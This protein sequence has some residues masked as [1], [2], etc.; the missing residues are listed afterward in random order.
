MTQV[1]NGQNSTE[2][3]LDYLEA[4]LS[5]IENG[6]L[7]ANGSLPYGADYF[8][9]SNADA[10]GNY[11][12]ITYKTGGAAGTTIRI[13]T[14]TFDASGNVLTWLDDAGNYFIQSN[15]DA[16]GNYQTITYKTGGAAGTVTAVNTLTFDAEGNVLTS[17]IV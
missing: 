12:T 15:A 3:Q 4:I 10:N 6:G 7:P 11:Q 17:T 9:Q 14:L 8:A 2:A 5:A 16:N 1:R 13:I